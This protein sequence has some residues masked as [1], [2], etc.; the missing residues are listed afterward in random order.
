[1]S[2]HN[3][4]PAIYI[5]SKFTTPDGKECVDALAEIDRLRKWK[6]EAIEVLNGWDEVSEL[7]RTDLRPEDLGRP[8]SAIIKDMI[9]HDRS[10]Q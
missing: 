6:A 10:Q 3:D 9:L 2:A 4:Y 1:M 8:T 5:H 7:F